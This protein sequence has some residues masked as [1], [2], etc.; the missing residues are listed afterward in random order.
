MYFLPI[1]AALPLAFG[2]K[3]VIPQVQKAV[4]QQLASYKAYTAYTDGP[5]GTLKAEAAKVT[6]KVKALAV[7]QNARVAQAA[8]VN[9][10]YWYEQIQHQGKSAFNTNGAYKVYRNVKDYGAVG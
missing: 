7:N 1:L 8:A 3:L 10:P 5:T 4:A 2:E 6:P 9:A